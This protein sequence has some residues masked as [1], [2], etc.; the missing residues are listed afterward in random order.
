MGIAD[1]II[2]H[3]TY[4]DWVHWEGAWELIE[5]HPI[6]MSPSPV[7]LHQ[8]V[9][10]ELRTELVLSL[11]KAKCKN[12]RVYDPLDYKIF[13]DTILVPD[14]MIICGEVKKKYLDFP[15]SLV[16]EI[17]SPSTALRDRHTKYELYQQQGVKY[18]LIVDADKKNI[19]VHMLQEA[20]YCLQEVNNSFVFE[21]NNDCRITPDLR[22]VFD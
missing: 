1:K 2:P 7:P 9:A 14:I 19:E 8:R 21:L 5:G 13:N 11:R 3:Y 10:A 17:L 22:H 15:P 4:D 6:A 18:Y 20:Q 12:C 16:V